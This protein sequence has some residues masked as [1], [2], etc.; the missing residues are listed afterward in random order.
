MTERTGA[1]SGLSLLTC[2]E[3]YDPTEERLRGG[4]PH[5]G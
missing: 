4:D 2:E 3:G 5:H 1:A